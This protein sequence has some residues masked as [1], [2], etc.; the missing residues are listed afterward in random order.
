MAGNFQNEVAS[1][2]S[3]ISMNEAD[4]VRYWTETLGCSADELAAAV[5]RVGTSTDTVQREITDIGHSGQS[6][7]RKYRDVDEEDRA[8][9]RESLTSLPAL[10]ER[11]HRSLARR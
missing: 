11:C 7:R 9:K 2:R 4:E 1:D 3:R 6:E 10:G 5:A 8:S